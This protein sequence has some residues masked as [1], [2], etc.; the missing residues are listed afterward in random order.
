[1]SVGPAVV[2][3]RAEHGVDHGATRP[4]L[5][6]VQRRR[7]ALGHWFAFPTRLC[8]SESIDRG[9]RRRSRA[10]VMGSRGVSVVDVA[11]DD[12]VAQHDAAAAGAADAA[13]ALRSVPS[14]PVR[15]TVLL[16][17]FSVPC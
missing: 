12:R 17:R 6:A 3:E 8:P 7:R 13:A 14:E 16:R 11:G 15:V 5:V 2:G 1:M 9:R 4:D 10:N